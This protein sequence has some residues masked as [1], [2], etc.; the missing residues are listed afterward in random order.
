MKLTSSEPGIGESTRSG[1]DSDGNRKIVDSI[2]KVDITY[3]ND[4]HTYIT[5]G[6]DLQHCTE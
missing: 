1:I 6:A 2:M 3:A 5:H 4:L